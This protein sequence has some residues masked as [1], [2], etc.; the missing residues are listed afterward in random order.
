MSQAAAATA[1][2]GVLI[3]G[4]YGAGK[5]SAAEE[6]ATR[7]ERVG[8]PYG[9]ID[10]DWLGWFDVGSDETHERVLLRNVVAVV[11]TY[12]AV[13]VRYFVMAGF[14]GRR[15]RLDGLRAELPFPL[16]LVELRVPWPEIERR[17][18]A[19]P[20]SGRLDDLRDMRAW[21]ES[22]AESSRADATI[23]GDRPVAEVASEILNVLRWPG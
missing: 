22:G 14:L 1:A 23:E 20:T 11:T 17:L 15:S 19:S 6:I 9:A 8:L 7:L 16:T 18:R 3:S 10:M 21:I 2:S 12:L 4:L 13:G 5:S